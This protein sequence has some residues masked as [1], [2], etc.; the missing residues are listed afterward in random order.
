MTNDSLS[1][2]LFDGEII[3]RV[4]LIDSMGWFEETDV[5]R[6]LDLTN[7]AEVVGSLEEDERRISRTDTSRGTREV[8]VISESGVYAL[9]K[10][11]GKPNAAQFRKWVT[12]EVLPSIRRTG[13]YIQPNV[14]V[15]SR[16]HA[17]WSLEEWRIKLAKVNSAYRTFNRATAAWVWE[18]EGLP[19]PPPNLL[20]GWWQGN[21]L[22]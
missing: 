8:I 13:A 18:H 2:F 12:A 15:I 22:G 19:M 9:I 6:A 14:V 16:H 10:K 17:E 5:C 1:P 4:A 21:L 20:P 7:L 11:S 3:V